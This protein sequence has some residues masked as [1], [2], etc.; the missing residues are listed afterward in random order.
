MSIIPRFIDCKLSLL[1]DG[2]LLSTLT[3]DNYDFEV[4][5]HEINK[6]DDEDS[7][8]YSSQQ[9]KLLSSLTLQIQLCTICRAVYAKF[10]PRVYFF[11]KNQEKFPHCCF[12]YFYILL[13]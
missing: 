7:L 3:K 11:I 5:A 1:K 4:I 6:Y 9:S 2:K 8:L 10:I 13:A 12:V